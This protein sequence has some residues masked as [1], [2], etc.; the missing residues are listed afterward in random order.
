[1]NECDCFQA[2]DAVGEKY[3]DNTD[4]SKSLEAARKHLVKYY[5]LYQW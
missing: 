5:S 3:V 4:D 1:M 2:R